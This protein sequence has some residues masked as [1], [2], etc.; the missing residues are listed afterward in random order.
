MQIDGNTI[1]SPMADRGRLVPADAPILATNG[2]NE[3][4]TGG[5]PSIRW[6]WDWLDADDYD[7]WATTVLAGAR[8]DVLTGTTQLPNT[9]RDLTTYASATVIKP[10]F[11]YIENG[12]YYNVTVEIKDL[13]E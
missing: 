11:E 3:V 7:F 2:R 1:P 4:V 8:S 6:T 10:T 13:I 5:Y 9:D 12:I